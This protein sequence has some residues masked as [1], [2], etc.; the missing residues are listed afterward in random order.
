MKIL[1][2]ISLSIFSLLIIEK[3]SAQTGT[4][5]PDGVYVPRKTKVSR[6]AIVNPMNGQIVYNTD[7]NCFNIYQ[8]NSWQ[9]LTGFDVTTSESWTQ[10][11]GSGIY[12]QRGAIGFSIG[13]KGYY[14]PDNSGGFWEY[15][16]AINIWRQRANY[17]GTS[18][19][20]AVSF[21]IGNK[22]YFGTGAEYSGNA[23]VYK[24]DFWE[25]DPGTNAW[26]Q[27]ADFGGIGR[28]GALG[29]SIGNKGYIG[30]G[31]KN[32]TMLKD[33]WEYNPAT[34]TWI[35]KT[36]FGGIAR[37]YAVGFSVGSKGYIG[38][39]RTNTLSSNDFWEYAPATDTWTQKANFGGGN[40]TFA[41]GF[42]IGDKGYIGTGDNGNVVYQND[43]WEY[44]PT[45]D[46]W[47]QRANF[48]GG[49]RAYALGFAIN[50]KGYIGMG[51][52]GSFG[53]PT[54]FWEYNPNSANL[55]QQGNVFNEA[56]K[57][58]KL[59]T[60]GN[61]TMNG[62]L[63]INGIINTPGF[64]T[65]TLLNGWINYDVNAGYAAAGYFKDK[66]SVVHLKG[67]IKSGT[68]T[69][70]TPLLNLPA[71]Y[72]P[73]EIMIYIVVNSGGFGR[74]DV[75]PSGDVQILSGGNGFLSFD[76]I[77]FRAN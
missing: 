53:Y 36:D 66:H 27:K 21:S 32:S 9:K 47:T 8:K 38:T 34:D 73:S 28:M 43:F 31:I 11:K 44:N 77:S 42:S 76:G 63:N 1:L 59:D 57:L 25:Y 4:I 67:L 48:V 58:V 16:P 64:T 70:A 35:Q 6:D 19:R 13:D 62:G 45:T 39:G 52:S 54:D 17:P 75:Y 60:S 3:V 71:G 51:T 26:T 49:T 68:T 23:D 72:R 61:L 7:D 24:N 37:Y 12:N 20:E 29:F 40:R 46:S 69:T 2:F 10:K 41:V 55:T 30:T 65:P 50:N 22:G 56:N 14:G 15:D 33:F 18:H 5:A 74:V